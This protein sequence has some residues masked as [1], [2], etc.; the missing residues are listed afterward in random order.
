MTTKGEFD[1]NGEGIDKKLALHFYSRF[2]FFAE[3]APL[4]QVAKDAGEE[5][6]VVSVLGSGN[7][8]KLDTEDLGL[9]NSYSLRRG[10]SQGTL[11]LRPLASAAR[12][13]VKL[14]LFSLGCTYNDLMVEVGPFLRPFGL[15]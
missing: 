10:S 7:G 11:K 15:L 6:R 12:K 4:L 9:K 3:L 8:G 13:Q 2:K 5:A 14:I 1:D